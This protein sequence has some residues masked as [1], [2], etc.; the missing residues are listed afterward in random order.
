MGADE[1][2]IKVIL[3]HLIVWCPQREY[4]SFAKSSHSE[5]K[6]KFFINLAMIRP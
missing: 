5:N 4:E 3:T 2:D 1:D 6:I